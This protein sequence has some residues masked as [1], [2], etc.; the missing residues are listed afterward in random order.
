MLRVVYRHRSLLRNMNE[1]LH[2][3][4]R[5]QFWHTDR[6][7]ITEDFD[8]PG[9]NWSTM[10]SD[11]SEE[12]HSLQMLNE[13]NSIQ[14]VSESTRLNALLDLCLT[15]RWRR[16]DGREGGWGEMEN[17]GGGGGEVENGAKGWYGKYI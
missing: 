6:Y 4:I 9:I 3:I 12:N 17:G 13:E 14:N 7:C 16:G 11:R 10:S 2:N 1:E 15:P 5:S 8:F